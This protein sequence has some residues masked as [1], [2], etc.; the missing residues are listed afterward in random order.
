MDKKEHNIVPTMN[1]K[2]MKIV[3]TWKYD[4]PDDKCN[5][6]EQDLMLPTLNSLRNRKINANVTIGKC[7]HGF[8]VDCI[9]RWIDEGSESCPTCKTTWRPMNNVCSGN[10]IYNSTK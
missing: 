5:L 10:Y 2:N 9:N 4:I 3:G 7:Q 6:C 1:I 8:H